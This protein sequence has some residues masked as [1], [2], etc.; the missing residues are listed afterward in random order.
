MER[1]ERRGVCRRNKGLEDEKETGG[2]SVL[3]ENE[4][5]EFDNSRM[6]E[7]NSSKDNIRG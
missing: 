5:N 7:Y 1:V 6:R 2:R 4:E 3:K